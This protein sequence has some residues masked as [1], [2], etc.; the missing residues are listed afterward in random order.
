MWHKGI[1][2]APAWQTLA[3]QS[4]SVVPGASVQFPCAR[5]GGVQFLWP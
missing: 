2:T 1:G 3:P 5:L 4:V